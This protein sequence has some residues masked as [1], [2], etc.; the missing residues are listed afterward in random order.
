MFEKASRMQLRFDTSLGLL[1][2]EDLW[3]LPLSSKS[4]RAN[5]D[6]IAIGLHKQLKDGSDVSFVVKERKSD[7]VVQLKFDIVKHIIDVLL[8]EQQAREE[9]KSRREQKQKILAILADKQDEALKGKSIEELTALAE[10][11]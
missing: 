9:A 11:L 5:L 4:G 1:S 10:A 3:E 6:D 8:L 7:E 2:V